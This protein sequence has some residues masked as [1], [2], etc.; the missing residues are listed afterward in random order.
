MKP[1]FWTCF[2][3]GIHAES[4]VVKRS[5]Y[6]NEV[7]KYLEADPDREADKVEEKVKYIILGS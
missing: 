5:G 2:N 6:K 1:M 7:L 3:L 4:K